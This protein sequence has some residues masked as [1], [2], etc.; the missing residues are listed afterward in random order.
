MLIRPL[1]IADI[2]AAVAMNNAEVP[3]VGPTDPEH[4]ARFLDYPGIVWVVVIDE[5]LA[6]LL[7]ACEPGSP[8]ASVNYRWF[9][10]RWDDF[11]YVDRIVVDPAFKG[12]GIGRLL[13]EQLAEAYSR[14]AARM[15]CEVNLDP[16]NEDSMA[17]HT[18][19]GFVQV[20]TQ[21][22]GTKTV[23]LLSWDLVSGFST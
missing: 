18:R 13:Y 21:P 23:A 16:P 17:F 14:V 2:A 12:R 6:G 4:L 1:E 15:T 7:V 3:N 5:L 8:Y 19:M 20:G 10:E 9:D 11:I 22:V